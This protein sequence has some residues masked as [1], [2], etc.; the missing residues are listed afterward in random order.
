MIPQTVPNK[1]TN[2]VTA[3]VIASQGRLRSKRVSSSDAAICIASESRADSE[4]SHSRAHP[5]AGIPEMLPQTLR[6]ADWDETAPPRLLH[7]EASPPCE[8]RAENDRSAPA[9]AAARSIW[10]G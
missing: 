6:P 10:T 4:S 7:P 8:M 5:A 2:G 1:P 9:P 3:P